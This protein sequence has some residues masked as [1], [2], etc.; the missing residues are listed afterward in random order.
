MIWNHETILNETQAAGFVSEG[1]AQFVRRCEA[2]S[3]PVHAKPKAGRRFTIGG[4]VDYVRNRDAARDEP[5]GPR[6]QRRSAGPASPTL[7]K[8]Q[9]MIVQAAAYTR[10][11]SRSTRD[12]V[13]IAEVFPELLH[14]LA[15]AVERGAGTMSGRI[16]AEQRDA[17]RALD[18]ISDLEGTELW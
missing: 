16:L 9:K 10:S 5:P 4:L 13:H 14:G 18:L 17:S 3:G 15:A 11:R 2:G 7:Q 1:A 8:Q 6:P 12:F